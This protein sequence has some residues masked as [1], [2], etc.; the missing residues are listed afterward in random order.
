[1]CSRDSFIG[2]ECGERKPASPAGIQSNLVGVGSA[3]P[4]GKL[5]CLPRVKCNQQNAAPAAPQRSGCGALPPEEIDNIAVILQGGIYLLCLV[6]AVSPCV[7]LGLEFRLLSRCKLTVQWHHMC[8]FIC[9]EYMTMRWRN[10]DFDMACQS[11]SWA[12]V[13]PPHFCF[14]NAHA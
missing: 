14:C 8:L 7:M 4:S 12:G 9:V 1:V 3:S 13:S 6:G 10:F 11:L 5:P 2:V